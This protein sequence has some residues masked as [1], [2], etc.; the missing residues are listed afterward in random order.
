MKY[1]APLTFNLYSPGSVIPMPTLPVPFGDMIKF[2]FV[3]V[4]ISV[5][6]PEKTKPVEPI[7]LFVKVKLLSVVATTAVST[8]TSSSPTLIPVPAPTFKV[9][10]P[11]VPPSVSPSPAVTDEISPVSDVSAVA[12]ERAPSPSV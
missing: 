6:A 9:T 3:P 10:S 5:V 12:Q 2:S 7:V 1:P 4:V 8:A 11:E